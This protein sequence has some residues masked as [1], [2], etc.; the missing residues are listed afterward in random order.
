MHTYSKGSEHDYIH[1]W[2]FLPWHLIVFCFSLF[3]FAI[4]QTLTM[5]SQEGEPFSL[6]VIDL[7]VALS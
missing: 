3:V 2:V 6:P 4:T 5:L 1:D 7:V